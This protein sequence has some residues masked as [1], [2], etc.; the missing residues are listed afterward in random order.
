MVVFNWPL[1]GLKN[2]SQTINLVKP[3]GLWFDEYIRL[4]DIFQTGHTIRGVFY[5][6]EDGNTKIYK[7]KFLG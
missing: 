4:P 7:Y 5:W 1:T 2:G 6:S 3:S